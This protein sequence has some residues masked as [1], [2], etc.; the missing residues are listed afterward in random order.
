MPRG[1]AGIEEL[2]RIGRSLSD[3]DDPLQHAVYLANSLILADHARGESDGDSLITSFAVATL[4]VEI[5]TFL[6][7]HGVTAWGILYTDVNNFEKIRSAHE[8]S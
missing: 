7:R 8:N 4:Q 6:G 3:Q 1:A 5:E 2:S